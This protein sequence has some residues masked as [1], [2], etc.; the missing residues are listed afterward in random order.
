MIAGRRRACG[1]DD[2]AP[3]GARERAGVARRATESQQRRALLDRVRVD[4]PRPT[5][6]LGRVG[7]PWSTA[8]LGRVNRPRPAADLGRVGRPWSTADLVRVGRPW[9]TA[10]LSRVDRPRSTTDL[11][12]VG[13]PWS[14]A[15]LGRRVAGRQQAQEPIRQRHRVRPLARPALRARY[16]SSLRLFDVV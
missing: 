10:D 16:R 4:R 6:D 3:A 13:R 9:S 15:D 1:S 14:T 11:G 12:R 2:V 7:R 5:A 8:D